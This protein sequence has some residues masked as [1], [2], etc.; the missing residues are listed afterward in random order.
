MKLWKKIK[1]KRKTKNKKKQAKVFRPKPSKYLVLTFKT[2]TSLA[3]FLFLVGLLIYFLT[4]DYFKIAYIN[5]TKKDLPCSDKEKSFFLDFI[6]ENIFLL[7]SNNE[8]ESIKKNYP[9][10]ESLEVRKELPNKVYITIKEREAFAAVTFD[11]KY[12]Y[13]I[14]R[15]GYILEKK[16]TYPKSKP[17]IILKNSHSSFKPDQELNQDGLSAG[18]FILELIKDNFLLF[19][20]LVVDSNERITLFLSEGVV[21]TLSAQKE[22]AP[23]VDSLQFILRQ[24]KI[25]GDLPSFIDLRFNKPVVRY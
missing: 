1:R 2:L 17:K 4:G 19:D 12:W 3:V 24:S 9:K 20:R 10:I 14:D 6:G 16:E 7:D 13:L 11:Q 18:L 25:E 5:C 23:Q 15:S 21:A 22:V 8:T